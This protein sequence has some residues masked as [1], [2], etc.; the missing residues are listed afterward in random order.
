MKFVEQVR[1]HHVNNMK[2]EIISGA[3]PTAEE[4]AMCRK[5]GHKSAPVI[6]QKDTMP[7]PNT[8]S[9]QTVHIQV[10]G[11]QNIDWSGTDAESIKFLES[12]QRAKVAAMEA[13][14][15]RVKSKW[16]AKWELDVYEFNFDRNKWQYITQA[17]KN[18]ISAYNLSVSITT[19]PPVSLFESETYKR[20]YP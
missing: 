6:L 4:C 13:D 14:G 11:W 2:A 5:I 9:G 12:I 15:I 1:P 3:Y 16:N 18:R 7:K 19:T 8:T 10:R 20:L 17:T